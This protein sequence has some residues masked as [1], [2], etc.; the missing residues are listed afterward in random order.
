MNIINCCNIF[1]FWLLYLYVST[2]LWLD[3]LKVY[4]PL[5][6]EQMLRFEFLWVNCC[7]TDAGHASTLWQYQYPPQSAFPGLSS[8]HK[9]SIELPNAWMPWT[10]TF[11][12]KLNIIT[13]MRLETKMYVTLQQTNTIATSQALIKYI[14]LLSGIPLRQRQYRW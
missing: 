10:L 8:C 9:S 4:F 13:C 6:E 14:P 2:Y 1:H 7:M 5:M 12:T 3:S 11:W